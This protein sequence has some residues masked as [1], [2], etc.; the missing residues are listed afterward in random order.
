[1]KKTLANTKVFL[2]TPRRH[3]TRPRSVRVHRVVAQSGSA[4]AWGAGVAGSNPVNPTNFPFVRPC[5]ILHPARPQTFLLCAVFH[6]VLRFRHAPCHASH[7]G[8]MTIFQNQTYTATKAGSL[9]LPPFGN[10]NRENYHNIHSLPLANKQK[11][12][13]I[14]RV[15]AIHIRCH[16]LS[17]RPAT[18]LPCRG[19]G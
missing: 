12:L 4:P 9:I 15:H 2:Y 11:I 18:P 8:C 1:M 7:S 6:P 3:K 14:F 13:G 17:V 10:I 19:T 5:R 16:F